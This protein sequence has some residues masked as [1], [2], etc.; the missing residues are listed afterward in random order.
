ML[1][2][3]VTLMESG[4]LQ[5]AKNVLAATK[6]KFGATPVI[7]ETE[8]KLNKLL[9]ASEP[10]IL[11]VVFSDKKPASLND[12]HNQKLK[13]YQTVYVGFI[14]KNFKNTDTE[15]QANLLDGTGRILISSRKITL[16]TK[17]GNMIFSIESGV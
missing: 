5:K 7:E 14:Y 2:Y 10:K 16:P 4:E 3:T 11:N 12:M 17:Q 15:I 8:F 9:R 13:V 6:E 1:E